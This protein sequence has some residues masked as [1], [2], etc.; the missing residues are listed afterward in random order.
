MLLYLRL[1]QFFFLLLFHFP[2]FNVYYFVHVIELLYVSSLNI[3]WVLI[4]TGINGISYICFHRHLF[5]GD[6][7]FGLKS[8]LS[9]KNNLLLWDLAE[10]VHSFFLWLRLLIDGLCGIIVIFGFHEVYFSIICSAFHIALIQRWWRF[11]KNPM[12]N[13]GFYFM[14]IYVSLDI[15]ILYIII[16]AVDC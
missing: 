11:R 13:R 8:L 1:L 3:I 6:N 5:L 7:G 14:F 2:I 12:C 4:L 9:C 10:S 16:M 15:Y